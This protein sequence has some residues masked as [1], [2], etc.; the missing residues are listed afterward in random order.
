LF[1]EGSIHTA[2]WPSGFG[3]EPDPGL[4]SLA[5]EAISAVR[6]AKSAAKLSMRAPVTRLAVTCAGAEWALLSQ[7]SGDLRAAGNIEHL[8]HIEGS[9]T[10]FDVVI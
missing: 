7:A 2:P 5:A 9:S 6:R 1:Q 8:E 10:S 3:A 4:L